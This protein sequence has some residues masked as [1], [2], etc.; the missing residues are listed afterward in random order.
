MML[1][2]EELDELKNKALDAAIAA[3]NFLNEKL[4]KEVFREEGR[5]IKLITD[6]DTENLLDQVCKQ[7]IFQYWVKSMGKY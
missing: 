6:Q 4:E 7:L 1:S 5:D 3:G 2:R